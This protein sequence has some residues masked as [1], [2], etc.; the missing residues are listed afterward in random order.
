MPADDA[1]IFSIPPAVCFV[2]ALAA[3]LLRR[4]GGDP[5]ALSR[6]S[7]LLPTRRACRTLRDGFLRAT[8]G[9]PLLLPR[10]MPLGDLDAEELELAGEDAPAGALDLP[11]AMPALARRLLLSQLIAKWSERHGLMG[12]GH[13]L[14]ADQAANLAGEL[15]RLLDQI[16]TE[17][18]SFDGLAGLVPEDYAAHWQ[19]T[20]RFLRI[21]SE[22]WPAVQTAAGCI[23]P[24]ERRRRLLVA[25][26]AAWRARPPAGPVVVAGSTGSI[27]AT[28]A[29]IAEVAR[30]PQGLIVLPGLDR[31]AD[32]ATWEALGEDPSHPQHGMA[33]LLEQLG[34]ERDRVGDWPHGEPAAGAAARAE[35]VAAA[36]RPAATTTGWRELAAGPAKARLAGAMDGVARIDCPG[37]SEEAL[38][39]ALLLRQSLDVEGRTASLVT[40]DRALA[41]RVA[42]ELRRW[43]I[44]VDDSAGTPLTDTAPGNF[45]RLTARMMAERLAPVALLAALKHPLAAGGRSQGGFRQKVRALELAVLR[46]PRPAPDF[47]GL[48]AA[49]RAARADQ[50]LIAWVAELARQAAPFGQALADRPGRLE[51]IFAAHLRFAEWLAG[52]H[53]TGGHAT[54]GHATGGHATGGHATGGKTTGG[55]RRLWQKDAGEAAAG[56]AADLLAAA[57]DAPPVSGDGY[58]ALLG[59]LMAGRVVR[60]RY[61]SH[62]RLAILGPLEARLQHSDVV[63]LGG[64]NEA[65]WPGEVD[66]GP[67]LSRPMRKDFGLPT[68]ERRIGLAAHDFAQLVAAPRVYL[69]RATRVEG[70]PTVPSRWLLRLDAL[71]SALGRA[72]GLRQEAT[73]WLAWAGQ[74]DRPARLAP[75]GPPSPRPPV[76]ARPRSLS[77][78]R[79]ETWMRNPYGL[80]ARSI[81]ALRPL[82]PLDADPGAAEKGILIHRAL[83]EFLTAHPDR[84]PDDPAAALIATGEAVF[85]AVRAKPGLWAFWWPRFLRIARWFAAAERHR[86][87]DSRRSWSEVTGTLELAGPAGPFRLLAKADRIDHLAGGGL[88]ILDYKTGALPSAKAIELGFAPQLPLEAAIA[89]AGGFREVPGEA[90]PAR[91]EF[92]RLTGGEPPGEAKLVKGDP[93]QLAEVALDGLRRLVAA[94]DQESTAYT[95]VPRPDWAPR[96]DDYAHLARIKEWSAGAV[97]EE[98]G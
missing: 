26:A 95:A 22:E 19:T 21:L 6:V 20:L 37:A 27:P 35:F 94:Y 42:A 18:L 33:R 31:E 46:G 11:P 32:A 67:W 13:L 88:A 79:V 5:V 17:G 60:P 77:V 40:P 81:L 71:L 24:A 85:E 83:E 49:L 52:G 9:R 3:G 97:G 92:W 89:L 75:Q 30:L 56:F 4:W 51:R 69:T 34:V 38:V 84:L 14:P 62:P 43:D 36:L 41:R 53:A 8:D 87:A 1:K 80:Y 10:L 91:L 58:T 47:A 70:T 57:G 7:V 86:R 15:A 29:L 82:E 54:G 96:F 44:E 25:Q 66:P 50:T 55:E 98:A 64:L 63:V 90:A 28:A 68:P 45:L 12:T 65:T 74:L 39:I 61:G 48:L 93:R 73:Q 23:G 76:A 72:D 59:A 78:T 2:D 16:E